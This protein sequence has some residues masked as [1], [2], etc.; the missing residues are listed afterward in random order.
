MTMFVR[1][2]PLIGALALAL[3][4]GCNDKKKSEPAAGGETS[5]AATPA[6]ETPPA[7]PGAETPAAA[8]P[9]KVD[10]AANS[11]LKI[12]VVVSSA[13]RGAKG[14]CARMKQNLTSRTSPA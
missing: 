7:Q 12:M 9:A 4:F 6:T 10:E 14:D 8:D 5:A 2:V 11:G 3:V 13:L 1:P